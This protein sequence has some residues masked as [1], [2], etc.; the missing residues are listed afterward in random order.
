MVELSLDNVFGALANKHRRDILRRCAFKEQS[1][2]RLCNLYG[3]T[4]AAV[5]KHIT[6]LERA[7]LIVT[8]KQG[9]ERL[10]SLDPGA[11]RDA[12]IYLNDIEAFWTSQLDS[13]EAHLESNP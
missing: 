3:I 13:L 11:V 7:G 6:V 8:R 5:A 10:A 9:K 2:S 12:Q 1:A 4:L